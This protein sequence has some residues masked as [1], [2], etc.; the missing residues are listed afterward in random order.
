MSENTEIHLFGEMQIDV[1][2]PAD[3]IYKRAFRIAEACGYMVTAEKTKDGKCYLE[4]LGEDCP[5]GFIISNRAY[6]APD[7]KK[8]S[9]VEKVVMKEKYDSN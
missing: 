6:F 4:F 8:V 2:Q 5:D 7:T 9:K 3:Q 1:S